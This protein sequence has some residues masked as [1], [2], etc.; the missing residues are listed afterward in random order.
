MLLMIFT[1]Q[2]IYRND[3]KVSAEIVESRLIKACTAGTT[4]VQTICSSVGYTWKDS[5]P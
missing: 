1:C 3:V 5:L 4:T 2:M